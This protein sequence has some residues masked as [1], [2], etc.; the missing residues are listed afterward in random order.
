MPSLSVYYD[1]VFLAHDPPGGAFV[2]P[3]HDW[4]AVE[5][6]HP[7][8]PARIENVRHAI[9]EAFGDLVRWES[10]EP[11]TREQLERVHDPDAHDPSPHRAN[12]PLPETADARPARAGV[13]Y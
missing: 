10:V 3:P 5:E 2:L 7:D 13:S 9:R 1:D 4:L 8:R 11:A 12:D 6:P